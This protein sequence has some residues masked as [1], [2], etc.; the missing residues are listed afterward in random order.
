MLVTDFINTLFIIIILTLLVIFAVLF[1]K[2]RKMRPELNKD[3]D[4]SKYTIPSLI[5][6][7]KESINAITRANLLELGLNEVEFKKQANKRAEL[8][9]H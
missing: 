4:A 2:S 3:L 6:H 8:K 1:L 9:R 7:I 5:E